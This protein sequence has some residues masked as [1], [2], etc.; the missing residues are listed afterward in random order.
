MTK[1]SNVIHSSIRPAQPMQL[2][3]VRNLFRWQALRI[4]AASDACC[5][6]HTVEDKLRQCAI[7]QDAKRATCRVDTS[8][9]ARRPATRSR[10]LVAYGRTSLH[11]YIDTLSGFCTCAAVASIWPIAERHLHTQQPEWR[12]FSKHSTTATS[13]ELLN[14]AP[15]PPN[16]PTQ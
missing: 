2:F 13:G 16:S 4:H 10:L 3:S 11:I 7:T 8:T 5:N 9:V 6:R 14:A 15:S 12:K 1:V